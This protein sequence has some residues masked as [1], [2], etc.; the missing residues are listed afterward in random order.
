[1]KSRPYFGLALLTIAAMLFFG[2]CNNADSTTAEPSHPPG[3]HV[4]ADGTVHANHDDHGHSHDNPPHGGTVLDWGGGKYHLEL[5][6]D[7]EK[8]QATVYVL[9]SNVKKDLPIETQSMELALENP[10]MQITL[11]AEPQDSDPEGESSRFVATHESFANDQKFS[12]MIFGTIGETPYSG[13][14]TQK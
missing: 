6:V 4:H 7:K 9:G 8:Q 14:F 12:G 13:D 10:K 3:T 5:C 2:G 11:S 1:M